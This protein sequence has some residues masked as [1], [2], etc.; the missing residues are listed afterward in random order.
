MSE[1]EQ[2]PPPVERNF[3]RLA[4]AIRFAFGIIVLAI[5][6]FNLR[7][8]MN[9]GRFSSIFRDMLG[10][11]P[12]PALTTL[13]LQSH[14]LLLLLSILLPAIVVVTMASRK[15]TRS[16]Y[17]LGIVG[18]I[19]IVQLSVTTQGLMGPFAQIIAG[20]SGQVEAIPPQN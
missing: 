20:L 6:Y 1:P 7:T 4:Y 19:T 9:I 14:T 3:V 2:P 18:L 10:T 16:F 15:V 17:I 13:I 5:C 8:T 11:K 12:L